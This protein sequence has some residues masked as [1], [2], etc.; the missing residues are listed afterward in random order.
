[1]PVEPPW[2]SSLPQSSRIAYPIVQRGVAE[3]LSSRRIAD[4]LSQGGVGIRRQ[5]LLDMM[6]LER[7]IQATGALFQHISKDFAPAPDRLPFALHPISNAFSYV[8]KVGGSLIATGQRFEGYVTVT[9]DK[10][11]AP[12]LIESAAEDATTRKGTEYEMEVDQVTIV[13]GVR[14]PGVSAAL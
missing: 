11:L 13:R 9:S 2:L 4:A 7:G 6:R 14:N 10:S 1:M 3:G 5:S 12:G 8:V